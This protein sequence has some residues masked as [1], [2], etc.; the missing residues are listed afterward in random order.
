MGHGGKDLRHEQVGISP[1]SGRGQV[2][3]GLWQ[4]VLVGS[5]RRGAIHP[6]EVYWRAQEVARLQLLDWN[7]SKGLLSCGRLARV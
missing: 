3:S 5:A 7:L 4:D 1:H 2:T 6:E